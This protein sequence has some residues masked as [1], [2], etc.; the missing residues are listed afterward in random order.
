MFII[1]I[2]KTHLLS[3]MKSFLI[4]TATFVL[5][6]NT[7]AAEKS[8]GPDDMPKG[9]VSGDASKGAALV[10]SCAA[11]H[12]A[13]GGGGVG[14]KLSGQ[15]ADYIIGRLT[16]YKNN[17]QVGPMSAM[18]WGQA[19]MLSENDIDTIGKFIQETMK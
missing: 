14:P 18:M 16:A 17:E 19:G 4:L 1:H 9:F 15:S 10:Q 6:F 2:T 5:A 7:N 11:C 8:L 3:F 13:D 12:G